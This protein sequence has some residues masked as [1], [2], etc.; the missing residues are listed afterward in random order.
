MEFYS[1]VKAMLPGVI[2]GK[3][4][5]ELEEEL[6]AMQ[7]MGFHFVKGIKLP[8][9]VPVSNLEALNT[10]EVRHDDVYAVTYQRSVGFGPWFDH[11]LGYWRLKDHPNVLFLKYEDLHKDLRGS[12]RKVA[13]HVGKDLSDDVIEC[14]AEHVTFRGMKKTYG[15]LKDSY[16]ETKALHMTNLFGGDTTYLRKG[17]V[18]DWKNVF[19]VSQNE[20]FDKIY[21][22]RMEGTNL[23]F[24]FEL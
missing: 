1:Q 13:E 22:L 14:I 21:A 5:D 9:V 18:G 3:T 23:E 6:A 8:S 20:L 7:K 24:D 17:K 10:F 11:V 16:G 2:N 4:L 15:E 12:I 19:T